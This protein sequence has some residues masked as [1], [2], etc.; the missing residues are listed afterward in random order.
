MLS[1]TDGRSAVADDIV[2]RLQAHRDIDND[3]CCECGHWTAHDDDCVIGRAV[4][5]IERLRAAGDVIASVL[6]SLVGDRADVQRLLDA[7]E[8]ARRG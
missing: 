6:A 5:E 8:K 4:A 7:W 1:L 3:R 2:T